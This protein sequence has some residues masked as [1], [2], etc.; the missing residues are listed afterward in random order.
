M[1]R[2]DNIAWFATTGVVEVVSNRSKRFAEW[3]LA[4]RICDLHDLLLNIVDG[5]LSGS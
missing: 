4:I 5:R 1:N 3:T 2:S